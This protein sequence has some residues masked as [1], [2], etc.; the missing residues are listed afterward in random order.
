LHDVVAHSVSII[1]MQAGAA[2]ELVERDPKQAREHMETVRLT[3]QDAMREMRRLVEVLREDD[4]TYAPQPTLA[5]VDELVEDARVAGVRIEFE[6]VGERGELPPGVDLAAYRI[7]Q[8]ALTNVRKHAVGAAARV[9]LQYAD[10]AID[11]LVTNEQ[12]RSANG[13]D[14]S[15]GG[16]GLAGMRERVRLYGGTVESGPSPDGG[17]LVHVRLPLVEEPRW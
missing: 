17:F 1:A 4:A 3:A 15:G 7:V 16:F 10:E 8:E 13:A 9:R 2:G 14:G 6:E 12:G 5:R 11:I